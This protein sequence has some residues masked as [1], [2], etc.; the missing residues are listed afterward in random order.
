MAKQSFSLIFIFLI[1]SLIDNG[2]SFIGN[3]IFKT[4]NPILFERFCVQNGKDLE[5]IGLTTS[6]HEFMTVQGIKRSVISLFKDLTPDYQPPSE[7]S[8]LSEIFQ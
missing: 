3:D 1:L 2:Q 7:D 8:S 6:T 4:K 5:D